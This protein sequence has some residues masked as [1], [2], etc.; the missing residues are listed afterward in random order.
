VS[1]LNGEGEVACRITHSG[2][3]LTLDRSMDQRF[4]DAPTIAP[5][6]EGDTDSL[7]ILVDGSTVEVFA[8]GGQVTMASRVY[9]DGGC[10][11][12]TSKTT[13]D[14]EI[15]RDWQEAGSRA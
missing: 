13:G 1:L 9:F 7:T 3:E 6:Q 5:L 15:L 11:G 8:D 4:A 14:A 10:S 2:D 12:I